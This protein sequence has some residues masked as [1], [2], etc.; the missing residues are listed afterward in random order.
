MT[1]Y[2]QTLT[3]TRSTRLRQ[4]LAATGAA[5]AV[6]V[7]I[8]IVAVPLLGVDLRGPAGPLSGQTQPVILPA[9]VSMSLGAALAAWALLSILERR[10]ARARYVWNTVAI[11]VLI[12]SYGGPL[13]AANVPTASRITLALMHTA[14]GLVLIAALPRTSPTR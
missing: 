5:F 4:R 13:L 2:Q 8:W 1:T 11:G 10:S 9:V 7:V 14:V 3:P 12:L 6:A